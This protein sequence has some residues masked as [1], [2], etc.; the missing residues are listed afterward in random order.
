MPLFAEEFFLDHLALPYAEATVVGDTYYASPAPELPTRLR[1]GFADTRM[2]ERYDGLRVQAVHLEHGRIDAQFLSFA[3]Y[4]AFAERDRAM[5]W[6]PGSSHH[7]RFT[8]G[9]FDTTPQW[10]GIDATRLRTAIDR[11]TRTWFPG[12]PPLRGAPPSSAAAP[13]VPQTAAAARRR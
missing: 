10:Q 9:R 4:G 5:G 13:A 6:R 2:H 8:A 7:G 3:D 1:I 12:A 11:Y